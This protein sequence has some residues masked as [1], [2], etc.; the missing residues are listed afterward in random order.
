MTS[1]DRCNLAAVPRRAIP[2]LILVLVGAL[3]ASGCG[4]GDGKKNSTGGTT[5]QQAQAKCQ[6]AR[7]PSPRRVKKRKPPTFQLSSDRTY[8]AK[9]DTNCGT[10][11]I[12]LDAKQAPRTGGSFVTLVRE[13][14]ICFTVDQLLTDVDR[15]AATLEWTAFVRRSVQ[16]VRGVDWFV[17]DPQI[18]VWLR[19]APPGHAANR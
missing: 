13:R 18:Q 4:G 10:F 17:F 9:V 6:D 2:I 14:G 1:D 7:A 5:G 3:A 16:I 11:E 12:R 8:T 19:H 15:C